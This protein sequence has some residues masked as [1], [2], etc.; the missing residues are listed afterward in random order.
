MSWSNLI[1]PSSIWWILGLALLIVE[2]A[3]PGLTILFFGLGALVVGGLCFLTDLSVNAQLALFLTSSVILLL[4][5]RRPLTRTMGTEARF[6]GE[7]SLE[8]VGQRAL[9]L[10]PISAGSDGKVELHGCEWLAVA[11]EEVPAG[12][13]VQIIGRNSLTL[14]VKRVPR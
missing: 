10:E 2:F 4:V 5:F 14:L 11:D 7:D 1:Q 3:V 9:V 13:A 12:D 8:I 6:D